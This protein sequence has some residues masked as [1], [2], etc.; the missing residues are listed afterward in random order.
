MAIMKPD[1]IGITVPDIG[2][3]PDLGEPECAA[4]I[5]AFLARL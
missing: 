2:H 4:G 5:D 1:L 3:V